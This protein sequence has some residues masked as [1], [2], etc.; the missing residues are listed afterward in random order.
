MM[1]RLMHRYWI[2]IALLAGCAGVVWLLPA[3]FAL[4]APT[5]DIGQVADWRAF[6]AQTIRSGHLPLWN[7]YEYSGVPF[8]GGFQSA[9]LYP[10]NAVFLFL[11]LARALN[12]SILLHLAILGFG[13]ARWILRRGLHPGAAL[14]CGLALVCSGPVFPHVFAGHLTNLCSMAW[15]PW[16]LADLEA[17]A[18]WGEWRSWLKAAAA[19]CLQVVAGHPQYVVFTAIAAGIQMAITA[20]VMPTAAR[21]ATLALLGTYVGAAL[22]AAAQLFPG[23]SAS[24]EAV[25]SGGL[26]APEAGIYSF[27]PENLLTLIAPN[28]FG[29][30]TGSAY[31]GRWFSWEMSLYVGIG[32]LVFAGGACLDRDRRRTVLAG[33]N[34]RLASVRTGP[35]IL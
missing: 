31:W 35:R 23:V 28:F 5:T 16:I 8:L 1:L 12:F 27:P 3:G 32:G 24:A 17:G 33:W 9:L 10:L 19:I 7:P 4:G 15:A 20:Y 21:R 14:L 25:R 22:L 34:R 26:S 30:G 6:A 18:K 11:P 13:M 2:L 29:H